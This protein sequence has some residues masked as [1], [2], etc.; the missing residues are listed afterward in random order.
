[1]AEALRVRTPLG[2]Q[3]RRTPP[4][5]QWPATA[6]DVYLMWGAGADMIAL[7][8]AYL[9]SVVEEER[10]L[11]AA[12]Q[13]AVPVELVTLGGILPA[14]APGAA[15]AGGDAVGPLSPR[16]DAP[17]LMPADSDADA[18]LVLAG[19]VHGEVLVL[20]RRAIAALRVSKPTAATTADRAR[21]ETLAWTY[22]STVLDALLTG[23]GIRTLSRAQ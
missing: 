17:A 20:V 21:L 4:A 5:W 7:I 2:D 10:R 11:H 6:S 14:T 23:L 18:R 9:A 13:L 1:V 16:A 15:V 22:P 8:E 3:L 19:D 12:D